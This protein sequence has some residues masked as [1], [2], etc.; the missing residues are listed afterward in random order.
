MSTLVPNTEQLDGTET[1]QIYGSSQLT[2]SRSIA[3]LASGA[4][5]GIITQT[6]ISSGT[7][8][9]VLSLNTF[10]GW[11]SA[12]GNAKTVQIPPSS[13]SLGIII[14]NDLYG[15]AYTY[16]VTAVPASGPSIIGPNSVYTAYGSITLLDSS[17]GWV[18]I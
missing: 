16:A 18:S 13:G 15:S 12:T 5:S 17:I 9:T 1:I 11:N 6:I 10:I 7:S 2:T 14:I 3:D 8:H 4:G